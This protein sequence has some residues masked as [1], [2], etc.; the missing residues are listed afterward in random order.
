MAEEK[1]PHSIQG[2]KMME[3][4]RG[5]EGEEGEGRRG[6]EGEEGEGRRG[7]EDSEEAAGGVRETEEKREV[8]TNGETADVP[9]SKESTIAKGREAKEKRRIQPT[10]LE[11]FVTKRTNPR[12]ETP[13]PSPSF[14][15]PSHSPS[16]PSIESPEI[17]GANDRKIKV[18]SPKVCPAPVSPT[19]TQTLR[20]DTQK[21]PRRV[22]FCDPINCARVM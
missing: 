20:T 14:P 5:R 15:S 1:L 22:Q 18:L 7:R 4:G 11:S 17:M 21:K 2:S 6:R 3:R 8:Q 10:M 13:S 16:L 9:A 19:P 12:L